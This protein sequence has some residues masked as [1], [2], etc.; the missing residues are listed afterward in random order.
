[1][2]NLPARALMV[3]WA[4]ALCARSLPAQS[5]NGSLQPVFQFGGVAPQWG[6]KI[7]GTVTDP[8]G[9]PAPGVEVT[10]F[11]RVGSNTVSITDATGRYEVIYLTMMD[12]PFPY[13]SYLMARDISRNL[14]ILQKITNGLMTLEE[15]AA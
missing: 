10:L 14:A 8:S 6:H 1:M 2:K 12:G 3:I 9:A 5:T 13:E 7:S 4:L 15:A 11:P